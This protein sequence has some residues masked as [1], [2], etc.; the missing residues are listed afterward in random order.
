M[1]VSLSREIV[2]ELQPVL[3]DV[4][5]GGCVLPYDNRRKP[6]VNAQAGGFQIVDEAIE[7]HDKLVER[8][9]GDKGSLCGLPR[10]VFVSRNLESAIRR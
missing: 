4:L 7:L 3:L 10:D 5:G 8:A 1:I 2:T 6:Q 9:V